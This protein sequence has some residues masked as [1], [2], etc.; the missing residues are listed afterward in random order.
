MNRL[1]VIYL[2]LRDIRLPCHRVGRGWESRRIGS[3]QTAAEESTSAAEKEGFMA[4]LRAINSLTVK[5]VEN[6][7]YVGQVSRRY[8][9]VCD[10]G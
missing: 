9:A 3:L 8:H 4:M 1:A 5:K 7:R 2:E 10:V 6:A